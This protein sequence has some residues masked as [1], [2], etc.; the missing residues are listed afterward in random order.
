MI[1]VTADRGT[2]EWRQAHRC[3]VSASDMRAL[4]AR[5]TSKR[6]GALVERLV[7]D[8]E[9]IGQHTDEHPDPWAE[10]HE[11]DLTAGVARYARAIGPDGFKVQR[12]GLCQDATFSWLVASPHALVDNYGCLQLRIRKRARSWHEKH[13]AIADA[14]LAR[15]QVTMRVCG[16]EW[17]DLVDVWDAGDGL[18]KIS[19]RRLHFDAKFFLEKV[20]PA[21]VRF[22]QDVGAA[23]A[24]RR[25]AAVV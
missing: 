18:G 16:R 2:P 11:L 6:Y 17:C 19:R 7:Y 13:A 12:I 25:T 22:W 14:E 1:V 5:R 15:A 8:F 23:R 4:L 24:E 20:V 3:K 9:G 21:C 10:Q